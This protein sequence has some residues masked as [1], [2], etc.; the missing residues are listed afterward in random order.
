MKC[1][2]PTQRPNARD[3]TQ[4]IFHWKSG[5]RL[6]PN[7]KKYT[8]KKWNVHGQCK[9]LA[10]PNAQ[11]TNMLVIFA[12]GDAKI[13]SF[14]LGDAKVPDAR[15]CAFWWNIGFIEWY[16]QNTSS[17]SN[18]NLWFTLTRASYLMTKCNR[19]IFVIIHKVRRQN[20][21][22]AVINLPWKS[23][24]CGNWG[25]SDVWYPYSGKSSQLGCWR[26]V[27]VGNNFSSL[28]Q[29]SLVNFDVSS[30]LNDHLNFIQ[31]V[32]LTWLRKPD[33]SDNCPVHMWIK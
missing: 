9:K 10:S 12:L 27:T 14:A 17:H 19:E 13:L 32:K 18:C 31:K 29:P 5:L 1:T 3:P 4:P 21:T 33:V 28:Q 16:G 24:T 20:S 25:V 26:L 2:C 11:D 7:V 6:L 30:Y 22:D 23:V 15:Y 8:H